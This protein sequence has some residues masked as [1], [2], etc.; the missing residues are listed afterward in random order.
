MFKKII[1][2]LFSVYGFV[3]FL[4]LMLILFPFFIIVSFFPFPADGNWVYKIARLWAT[5]FFFFTGIRFL[6][7]N[8]K[9]Y[10][11]DT[12]FIIVSNHIS[13]MDIPM[14]LLATRWRTLRI[15]GKAEMTKIPIFGFIYKSGAITIK[16]DN[17]EDRKASVEK[18]K[19]TAEEGISISIYPEGTFNQTDQ[20]LKEFY[21]GAFR[22]AIELQLPILPVL[23]PDTSKRLNQHSI[24]SMTPGTCRAVFLPPISTT[25]LITDDIKTLK[26]RTHC[27]MS[28]ELV[29]LTR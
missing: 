6:P 22:L 14:M 17:A 29:K 19:Q 15:L 23:F 25:G 18:M 2:F 28:E 27:L 9:Y 1:T 12:T 5:L 20:P 24:F 4:A 8:K 7:V 16:R 21:D 13:Y 10:S 11:R 3:I 26:N